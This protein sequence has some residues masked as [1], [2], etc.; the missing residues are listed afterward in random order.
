MNEQDELLIKE[1]SGILAELS[2]NEGYKFYDRVARDIIAKAKQHYQEECE[3]IGQC[4]D[5]PQ[6]PDYC[7]KQKRLDRPDREK[8]ARCYQE[9]IGKRRT[10]DEYKDY[11]PRY[12]KPF[13]FEW[14]LFLLSKVIK[15]LTEQAKQEVAREILNQMVL[16]RCDPD[17]MSYF[18]DYYWLP[19][20]IYKELESRYLGNKG[21]DKQYEI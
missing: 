18:E 16:E 11:L 3:Y 14:E 13:L 20:Y 5:D 9:F 7:P 8:I 21:E 15:D 12:T 19:E 6:K 4:K 10:Q 2:P 1:I 17:V